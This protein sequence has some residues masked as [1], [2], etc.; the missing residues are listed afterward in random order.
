MRISNFVLVPSYLIFGPP[1]GALAFWAMTLLP[2]ALQ[3]S[4]ERGIDAQAWAAG[5]KLLGFYIPL[6]YLL[7][8]FPALGVSL[9][10]AVVKRPHWSPR[11]R[12]V[13]VTLCGVAITYA[14]AFIAGKASA[15]DSETIFVAAAGGISALLIAVL[16]ELVARPRKPDALR[17]LPV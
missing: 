4:I 15:W 11:G 10:H 12:L 8:F 1:L 16:F 17:Q 6:S 9:V 7:G 3:A 14:S 5:L 13:S 2:V